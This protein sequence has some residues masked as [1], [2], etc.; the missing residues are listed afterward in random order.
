MR[1]ETPLEQIADMVKKTRMSKFRNRR[2]RR[3]ADSCAPFGL[4]SVRLPIVGTNWLGYVYV[5]IGASHG[6]E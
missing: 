6:T 4:N 3:W 5:M 2:G 1:V